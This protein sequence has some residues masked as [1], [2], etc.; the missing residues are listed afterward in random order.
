MD[1]SEQTLLSYI[2]TSLAELPKV[3]CLNN[4]IKNVLEDVT[5]KVHIDIIL[6]YFFQ[7]HN[8]TN[9][10]DT[11]DI[12]HC[13]CKEW[14]KFCHRI[15]VCYNRCNKDCFSYKDD[16]Q[17]RNFNVLFCIFPNC[18]SVAHYGN[19]NYALYCSYHTSDRLAINYSE[20]CSIKD[21][22]KCGIYFDTINGLTYC[23][24][25]KTTDSKL[26]VKDG[27]NYDFHTTECS[28]C[29]KKYFILYKC[30]HCY[31]LRCGN[32]ASVELFIVQVDDVNIGLFCC[33]CIGEHE[34]DGKKN[35]YELDL[36]SGCVICSRVSDLYIRSRQSFDVR[37]AHIET[38][39]Y[40]DYE[41]GLLYCRTHKTDDCVGF[42][43]MNTCKFDNCPVDAVDKYCRFHNKM[44]NKFL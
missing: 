26:L 15:N 31:K 1:L 39:E 18:D 8:C 42:E 38:S 35:M 23:K 10:F 12:R 24:G 34:F 20:L 25:H 29:K 19:V 21:C 28:T 30:G 3:V 43:Y 27:H 37:T 4:V 33:N 16:C 14:C 6:S 9:Y 17:I 11:E 2:D 44:Y 32:C 40:Y 41:N 13:N 7:C 36:R 22:R 5:P